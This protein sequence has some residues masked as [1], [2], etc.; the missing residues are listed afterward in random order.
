LRYKTFAI[1]AVFFGAMRTRPT[2]SKDGCG[3]KIAYEPAGIVVLLAQRAVLKHV[4]NLSS[5]QWQKPSND[6]LL[7]M[8]GIGRGW[9]PIE[10]AR[11]R[12][13]RGIRR[14][15]RYVSKVRRPGD[16]TRVWVHR[17]EPPVDE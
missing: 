5:Q 2:A 4:L 8:K 11:C 17:K 10:L 14:F 12:V 13:L 15:E 3:A 1:E 7:Q 16:F 9:I 6:R